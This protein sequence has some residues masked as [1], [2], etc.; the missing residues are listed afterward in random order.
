MRVVKG[1]A[2]LAIVAV[3]VVAVGAVGVL[4]AVTARA[5]PQE[6]GIAHVSGLGT[7]VT[8]VR[9]AA[10][11]AHITA[12]LA[13]ITTVSGIPAP[14]GASFSDQLCGTDGETPAVK[15]SLLES[16]SSPNSSKRG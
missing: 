14:L 13:S 12:K 7:S 5:L 16:A 9:D 3:L 4:V 8:V 11:I 15:H 10:G 1:I 6:S 2:L